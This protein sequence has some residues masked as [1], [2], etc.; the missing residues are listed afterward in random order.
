MSKSN[1]PDYKALAKPQRRLPHEA[2]V[3]G[4]TGRL[5]KDIQNSSEGKTNIENDK[6][7]N[8]NSQASNAASQATSIKASNVAS[9]EASN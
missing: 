3:S 4:N 5:L 9:E 2:F 6:P 1:R 8:V 7:S